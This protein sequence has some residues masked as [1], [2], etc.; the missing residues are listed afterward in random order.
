MSF[1][2]L[3]CCGI[4]VKMCLWVGVS[5]VWCGVVCARVLWQICMTVTGAIFQGT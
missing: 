5:V 4:D 1:F 2:L 3:Q